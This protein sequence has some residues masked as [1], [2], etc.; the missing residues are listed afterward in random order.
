MSGDN[1]LKIIMT[2][3][4]KL[5]QARTKLGLSQSEMAMEMRTSLRTYQGW[6]SGR[7]VPDVAIRLAELIAEI[8]TNIK[9]E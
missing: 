6:E 4:E 7:N 3:T 9:D 5:K 8:K 1:H 2:N